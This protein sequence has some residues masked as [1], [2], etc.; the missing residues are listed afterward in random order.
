MKNLQSK[1]KLY[2]DAILSPA[3]ANAVKVP[4]SSLVLNCHLPR[5]E[6]IRIVSQHK[7]DNLMVD[8]EH[9]GRS[10]GKVQRTWMD[11][12]GAIWGRIHVLDQRGFDYV[13]SLQ[14]RNLLPQISLTVCYSGDGLPT[15]TVFNP[16][17]ATTFNNMLND[18]GG[19]SIRKYEARAVSLVETADVPFSVTNAITFASAGVCGTKLGETYAFNHSPCTIKEMST[20]E[21][22]KKETAPPAEKTAAPPAETPVEDLDVP[23]LTQRQAASML[24][25]TKNRI[26]EL[27]SR[28]SAL[29]QALGVLNNPDIDLN[30]RQRSRLQAFVKDPTKYA[31]FG[32]VQMFLEDF[33]ETEEVADAKGEEA[34]D[35]SEPA[36]KKRKLNEAQSSIKKPMEPAK[37][38]EKK[39]KPAK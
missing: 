13:Q 38:K 23:F 35:E 2:L 21:T 11:A 17:S 1:S 8:I 29:P 39:K 16:I 6:K 7:W 24:Y 9:D 12:Q 22:S 32:K 30:D 3:T 10:I 26:T 28:T 27:E 15:N 37:K 18:M 25:S 33:I 20:P 4:G 34:A 14:Q 5:E 31:D 36:Q 19:A